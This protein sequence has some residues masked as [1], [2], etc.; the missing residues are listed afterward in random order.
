VNGTGGAPGITP[1]TIAIIVKVFNC[2]PNCCANIVADAAGVEKTCVSPACNKGRP[3]A[4][5]IAI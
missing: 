3:G 2:V 4:V 1:D 5:T